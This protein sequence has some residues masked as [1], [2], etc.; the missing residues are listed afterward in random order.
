MALCR[1]KIF[2]ITTFIGIIK[3]DSDILAPRVLTP[4]VQQV[5]IQ[6]EQLIN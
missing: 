6:V 3:G 2:Y 1:L 4:E 5:I